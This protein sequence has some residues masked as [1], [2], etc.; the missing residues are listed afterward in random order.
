VKVQF[1]VKSSAGRVDT[2]RYPQYGRYDIDTDT[3]KLLNIISDDPEADTPLRKKLV[4][5]V[6]ENGV[7]VFEL[8]SGILN[9]PLTLMQLEDA[10]GNKI[11]QQEYNTFYAAM[12]NNGNDIYL[13]ALDVINKHKGGPH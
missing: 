7:P 8:T 1:A 10:A 12:R 2:S 5:I 9:S 6:E 4:M 3:E 11:F 13:S